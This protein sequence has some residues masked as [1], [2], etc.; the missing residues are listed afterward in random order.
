MLPTAGAALGGRG[1]SHDVAYRSPVEKKLGRACHLG[2][3]H[4][5][6][7]SLC[8]LHLAAYL[9][10]AKSHWMRQWFRNT[11][12]MCTRGPTIWHSGIGAWQARVDFSI[13]RQICS[14]WCGK[15]NIGCL[16]SISLTLLESAS[17]R[18]WQLSWAMATRW[19][20]QVVLTLH[21]IGL[22]LI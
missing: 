15:K 10:Q 6:L 21:G 5:V 12:A 7:H 1:S 13:E 14:R 16:F 11:L 20:M 3:H 17:R 8:G 22:S 18:P 2:K 9:I 4:D 19:T